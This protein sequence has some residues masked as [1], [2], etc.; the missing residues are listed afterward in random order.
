MGRGGMRWGAGR[1]PRKGKT[2]AL[3]SI[4]VRRLKREKL[5]A[6]DLTYG[7]HWRNDDDEV[8]ASIHVRTHDSGLTVSY[9]TSGTQVE[10]FVRTDTT[11]CNYGGERVWFVCPFC[12]LELTL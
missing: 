3:R 12:G 4:D 8:T 10:Q 5:L 9:A 11:P 7:W 1:P 6:G 2:S